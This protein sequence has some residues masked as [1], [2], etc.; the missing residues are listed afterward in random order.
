MAG[1]VIV[2]SDATLQLENGIDVPA[3][4]GGAGLFLAGDGSADDNGALESVSGDNA[5]AGPVYLCSTG[6]DTLINCDADGDTL[7]LTGSIQSGSVSGATGALT[8]GG[9]GTV[10]FSAADSYSGGTTVISG[11]LCASAPSALPAGES[12]IVGGGS[13]D[14]GGGGTE[15]S[16]PVQGPGGG[17][18][19]DDSPAPTDPGPTVTSV[20]FVDTHTAGVIQFN[21]TFS[22]VV[23]GVSVGS[24]A[25]RG[26]GPNATILSATGSGQTYVVTVDGVTGNCLVGLAIVNANG[27][28]DL[29]G[30][31]LSG[32]GTVGSVS[33][34][35][36]VS[37]LNSLQ[38]IATVLDPSNPSNAIPQAMGVQMNIDSKL[39]AANGG[40]LAGVT[41]RMVDVALL[42]V[43]EGTTS[44]TPNS[45]D[46]DDDTMSNDPF[47][48]FDAVTQYLLDNM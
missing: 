8:I 48:L 41:G 5:W 25:I 18:G 11:T 16:P 14:W 31:P 47:L 30:V 26:G 4:A 42:Q 13:F 12:L 37:C 33:E 7:T 15:V 24:F 21:V 36:M 27:I 9:A 1:E 28:S 35:G 10:T 43:L 2:N 29:S 39:L 17:L 32:S 19:G 45:S 40:T 23:Q 3:P 6:G 46:Y 20:Q 38:A 22:E 34:Q 44:V